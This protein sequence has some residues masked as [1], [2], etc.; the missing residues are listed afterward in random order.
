MNYY[1]SLLISRKEKEQL[2]IKLAQEGKTTRE[3]AKQAHV[4][5]REIGTII[6]KESDN[7][8][9]LQE[10][11][12]K[13]LEIEKQKKFKSLSPY[14]R[15]FQMFKDKKP[16]EDVAIELDIKSNAVLDYYNDYL[17]LTRM[18]VLVKIYKELKSDFPLFLHLYNR[19]KKEGLNKKDITELLQNHNKLMDLNEQVEFYNNH[20]KGQY[21]K[22]QQLVQ[23][24]NRLQSRIDNY[25]GIN[26]I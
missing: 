23:T 13:E 22:I 14:A 19:V 10:K 18:N 16:L 2:V 11:K 26:P 7:E 5:L 6:H 25:D 15:A 21:T 1:M 12:D 9:N 24:I 4:S 20:I 17:Q 3:I 8:Y